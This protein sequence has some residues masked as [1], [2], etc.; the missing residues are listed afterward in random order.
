MVSENKGLARLTA[1]CKNTLQ[2]LCSLT[3]EG[4]TAANPAL[5]KGSGVLGMTQRLRNTAERSRGVHN[6]NALLLAQRFLFK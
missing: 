5:R 4:S 1:L 3:R 2:G 6:I